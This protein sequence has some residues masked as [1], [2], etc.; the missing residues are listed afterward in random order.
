MPWDAEAAVQHLDDN[1]GASSTSLSRLSFPFRAVGILVGA[2]SPRL[3]A[4]AL[5]LCVGLAPATAEEL[6]SA[7]G[8]V[9]HLYA[10]YITGTAFTPLGPNAPSVF[11]PDLLHLIRQNQSQSD[12]EAGLLDHDPLCACQDYGRLT[13]FEIA[14]K[15]ADTSHADANVSFQNGSTTEALTLRLAQVDGQWRVADVKEPTIPSLRDF[16]SN[17]LTGQPSKP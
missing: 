6:A 9:R 7:Q 8:F 10:P 16:L 11:A 3:P 1:I 5:A 14:I 17:G 4:A 2:G 15:P 12:G 13:A